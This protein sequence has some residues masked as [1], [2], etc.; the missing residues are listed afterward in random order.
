MRITKENLQQ[1]IHRNKQIEEE[2]AHLIQYVEMTYKEIRIQSPEKQAL[3]ILRQHYFL[4]IP[5][6]DQ[7]FGGAIRVL[8]NGKK[9][10]LLIQHSNECTNILCIGMKSIIY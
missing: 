2:I 7:D 3:Q 4:Q 1:T 8:Q 10:S 6:P 5:I 9:S